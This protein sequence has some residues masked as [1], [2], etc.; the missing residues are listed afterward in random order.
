MGVC[1]YNPFARSFK[2]F[3]AETIHLALNLGVDVKVITS[4]E[5]AS[6]KETGYRLSGSHEH[7][8]EIV[9]RLQQMTYI[10]GMTGDGVND[11]PALKKA[12]IEIAVVD[13]TDVARGA[14]DIVLTEPGLSVIV[15]DVLT[16]R[17]IFQIM[18]NYTCCLHYYPNCLGIYVSCSYLEI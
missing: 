13:A 3:S 16:S 18:K 9:M 10:C 7:K 14:S 2:A 5:L 11:A 1:G 6:G 8:Y 15:S 12:G 17:A 4:D